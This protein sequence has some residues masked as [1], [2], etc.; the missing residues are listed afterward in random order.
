MLAVYD[1]DILNEISRSI[2][3]NDSFAK[4]R[5]V[6]KIIDNYSTKKENAEW[7]VETWFNS[8]DLTILNQLEEIDKAP[9]PNQLDNKPSLENTFQPDNNILQFKDN[10]DDVVIGCGVGKQDFGFV[11]HGLTKKN[12][13]HKYES[14]FAITYNFILR[15]C[16]IDE[17]KEIPQFI[18]NQ[19]T[20]FEIDYAVVLRLA[21]ILLEMIRNGY[22]N[23]NL[24]PI[25]FDGKQEY[26]K[27]AAG[28]INYY[29]SLFCEIAGIDYEKILVNGNGSGTEV[30]LN[31]KADIFISNIPR[32]S[33]TNRNIWC[34]PK[35]IY[36]DIEDKQSAL[37]K[38]LHE[39]SDFNTFRPGQLELLEKILTSSEHCVSIM[40]TGSGKSLVFYLVGIL[41]PS[42]MVIVC[43]TD[44]LIKD[45][46]RC[47]LKYHRFDDVCHLNLGNGYDLSSFKP[48]NK[49]IFLTPETFQNSTL[50]KRFITLIHDKLITAVVLDEIHCISNWSHDFRPEYLMLSTYLKTYLDKTCYLG[51]TATANYTVVKDI[52]N[53]L[54]ILKSNVFSP[55]NN[56]NNDLTFKYHECS[57]FTE[58]VNQLKIILKG[59][60]SKGRRSIV[61]TK[62]QSITKLI[63]QNFDELNDDVEI[64]D[65]QEPTTYHFFA[66]NKSMVLITSDEIGIGINLPNI[67][68]IIH[69]GVPI[70]KSEY[71]QQIGRAG[72]NGEKVIAY[73][74]YEPISIN[75]KYP[76]LLYRD[77]SINQLLSIMTHDHENNDYLLSFI[78]IMSGIPLQTVF[79]EKISEVIK[80]I[81]NFKESQEI[82][83]PSQDLEIIKRCLYV[84]FVIGYIH[85]WA[86]VKHNSNT[87]DIH[88]IIHPDEQ[89]ISKMKAKAK[90][91]FYLMGE[92]RRSIHAVQSASD[93][94][95]L[96]AVYINWYYQ[97]FLYHHKEQFFDM[98]SL[99]TTT[100]FQKLDNQEAINK[101]IIDRLRGYFSLSIL[102]ISEDEKRLNELTLST[103]LDLFRQNFETTRVSNLEQL[104]SNNYSVKI[105]FALFI[106]EVF[107]ENKCD[108]TRLIR[109][110]NNLSAGN[111]NEFYEIFPQ[112]YERVSVEDRYKILVEMG[113]YYK[114]N[115][116]F[117]KLVDQIYLRL[118]RDRIFYGIL[119]KR[120]NN[121]F[122]KELLC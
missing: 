33:V 3:H 56:S 64:F 105:D 99:C 109:I 114:E 27:L 63:F 37:L 46:I 41:Q 69:F 47:L 86:I 24:M 58:M 60:I 30:S 40:P 12:R 91:Y 87:V 95:Q 107:E 26:L 100:D 122:S 79:Q 39:I 35:I 116:K 80:R 45:Q 50:I 72:R 90:D 73:L 54:E 6:F 78:K 119:A 36:K 96:L 65:P 53:Q 117:I 92:N 111:L 120:L 11:I 34:A 89:E 75:N 44:L 59:E 81:A 104:I 76:E 38:I 4:N 22:A 88:L 85:D 74:L 57:S 108:T 61:F 1:S 103:I 16:H 17:K 42:F 113:E 8:I 14:I 67:S 70:S 18:K 20:F 82:T 31:Q 25:Q 106:F 9:D 52:C 94:P 28:L 51:F 49:L 7:A 83:I 84:L 110:I 93:L 5:M 115:D 48:S 66:D 68:T 101:E 97:H 98:V 102:D 71:V 23:N 55:I 112:V 121:D 21:I 29:A 43:P 77:S 118:K 62:N 10:P 2:L 19:S 15:N 32:K 13:P